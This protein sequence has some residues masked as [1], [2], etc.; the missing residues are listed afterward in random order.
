KYAMG[1]SIERSSATTELC[2]RGASFAIP[3]EHVDGMDVAA[4]R[5]AGERAI[6]HARSG[7]GPFILEM[8]TYRYRGHSMSDP[9]KYR[10]REE[11]QQMRTEHDPIEQVRIR[12]LEKKLASED[13]LKKVDAQVRDIVNEAAEFATNDPEP[14]AAELWTNVYR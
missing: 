5:S 2:Q 11:V 12:M 9:A 8:L 6:A 1:T 10:T 3:G 14:D 7:K 4:V 13:E